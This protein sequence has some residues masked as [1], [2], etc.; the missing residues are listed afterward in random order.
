MRGHVGSTLGISIPAVQLIG[1]H[2]MLRGMTRRL[3]REEKRSGRIAVGK[4][5]GLLHGGV[6]RL[7]TNGKGHKVAASLG[8]RKERGPGVINTSKGGHTARAAGRRRRGD[9]RS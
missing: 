1:L 6:T 3:H 9:P 5:L 7:S 8:K 4:G 2:G